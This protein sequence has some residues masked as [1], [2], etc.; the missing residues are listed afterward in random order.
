MKERHKPI[1]LN[2]RWVCVCPVNHPLTS[3]LQS[4]RV[5]SLTLAKFQRSIGG[6]NR[7]RYSVA[8]LLPR[9]TGAAKSQGL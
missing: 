5:S 8:A 3:D 7:A 4:N 6:G 9:L 2:G 1:D